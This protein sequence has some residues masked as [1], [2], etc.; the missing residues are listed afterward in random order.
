MMVHNIIIGKTS[1][2][3]AGFLRA[4]QILNDSCADMQ[5]L[6]NVY[7]GYGNREARLAQAEATRTSPI[8]CD[9]KLFPFVS[10]LHRAQMMFKILYESGQGLTT[11]RSASSSLINVPVVPTLTRILITVTN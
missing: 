8:Y 11:N 7:T 5:A 4:N 2:E 9:E 10:F 3:V 1:Q 6:F